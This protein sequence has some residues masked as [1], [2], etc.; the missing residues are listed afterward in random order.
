MNWYS[1]VIISFEGFPETFLM[2]Y[3]LF[4]EF[5]AIIASICVFRKKT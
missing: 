3:E 2:G 1:G 4:I 5:I